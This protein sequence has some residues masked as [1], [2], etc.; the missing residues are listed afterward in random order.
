VTREEQLIATVQSVVTSKVMASVKD[1]VHSA[2]V[3]ELR[4][5]L[6]A[7]RSAYTKA[8]VQRDQWKAKAGEYRDHA[9]KYQRALIEERSKK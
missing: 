1:G 5:E 2:V 3:K 7:M 6:S 9:T 8:S 4:R